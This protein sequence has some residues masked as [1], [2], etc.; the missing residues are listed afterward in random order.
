MAFSMFKFQYPANEHANRSNKLFL[1]L[2]T[3]MAVVFILTLGYILN[4]SKIVIYSNNKVMITF[5]CMLSC[6]SLFI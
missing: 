2:S 1:K 4:T 5:Q 3:F 6:H